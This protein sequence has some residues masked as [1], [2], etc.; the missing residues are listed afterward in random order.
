M[1]AA[2]RDDFFRKGWCVLPDDPR[3]REW[4]EHC[5]PYAYATLGH[6][7]NRNW[8]RCGGTW[9]AGVNALHNDPQGRIH[10]GPPLTGLAVDFLHRYLDTGGLAWDRAQISICYPG[11]PKPMDAETPTAFQYRLN[12]DAAHVDGLLPEG[13]GRRRFL[14]EHHAFILGIPLV[15]YGEG[16]SPFVIWEGSHQLVREHFQNIFKG[17]P[18]DEWRDMDITESYHDLRRMI[19]ER[20]QRTI[21]HSNPGE[22]YLAHRLSLH[23]VSPWRPG[24]AC[25]PEGRMICY[26]RPELGDSARWLNHP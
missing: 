14:R 25:A 17:I 16:A 23:G 12:R 22:A 8:F 11:Y 24:A 2:L 26:F 21:V 1:S 5:R 7:E 9:F 15:E 6:P 20:C 3:L 13:A 18:P 10:G 4:V 19:F